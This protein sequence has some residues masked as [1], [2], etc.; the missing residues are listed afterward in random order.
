MGGRGINEIADQIGAS[1]ARMAQSILG[2]LPSVEEVVGKLLA[3]FEKLATF[4][5]LL[6][7]GYIEAAITSLGLPDWITQS[8]TNL[9]NS[10]VNIKTFWEENGETIKTAIFDALGSIWEAIFGEGGKNPFETLSG[11]FLEFTENLDVTKVVDAINEIKFAILEVVAWLSGNKK[12][13]NLPLAI[14]NIKTLLEGWITTIDSIITKFTEI[15]NN[16]ILV[17][18]VVREIMS[19]GLAETTIE[20]GFLGAIGNLFGLGG[21]TEAGGKGMGKGVAEIGK[22]LADS[23]F[24]SFS[25]ETSS[26]SG[27]GALGAIDT[28]IEE[29]SGKFEALSM[30]LV[31][32]SIIPEM[33]AAINTEFVSSSGTVL[34]TTLNFLTTLRQAFNTAAASIVSTFSSAGTRAI[35]GFIVGFV[36]N[37][38]KRKPEFETVI[39]EIM[40]L[41]RELMGIDSPSKVFAKFGAQMM[42]GMAKGVERGVPLVQAAM[43]SVMTA[44]PGSASS[45]FTGGATTNNTV[46]YNVSM[47]SNNNFPTATAPQDDLAATLALLRSF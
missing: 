47:N 27:S 37:W 2:T 23:I 38:A 33:W 5:D 45:P 25:T 10:F 17:R 24:E 13:D 20:G 44:L 1:F 22:T 19:L 12:G 16:A 39:E 30:D 4:I 28:W 11:S 15:Y 35:D 42:A 26:G 18:D 41:V 40:D 29:T 21:G 43:E 14:S 32:H 34:G 46:N 36:K 31:G 6:S 9:Y 3:S 7:R 8:V